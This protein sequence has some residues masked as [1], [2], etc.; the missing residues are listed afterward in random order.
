MILVDRK[1]IRYAALCCFFLSLTPGCA[2][3]PQAVNVD[4][5]I[6][7][8]SGTPAREQVR[9]SLEVVD[10]RSDAVIGYRGGVYKT[11]AITASG[12]IAT[13]VRNRLVEAYEQQRVRVL[14]RVRPEDPQVSVEIVELRY[15]TEGDNFV[16][17]VKVSAAV[18]AISKTSST[19]FTANYRESLDKEVVKAPSTSAN[20]TLIN[21]V[22]G[23]TLSRLAADTR[24]TAPSE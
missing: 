14:D 10:A 22:L 17:A 15:T 1:P 2:L 8:P 5:Q 18:R 24:I 11:A 12:D 7:L 3:S 13:S 4:P 9:L 16:R 6:S 23:K 20:E 21:E 19:S